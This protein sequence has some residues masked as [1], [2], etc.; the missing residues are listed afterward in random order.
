MFTPLLLP[1]CVR[2]EFMTTTEQVNITGFDP[3]FTTAVNVTSIPGYCVNNA[4]QCARCNSNYDYNTCTME[5]LVD[6]CVETSPIYN[7]TMCGSVGG[8][9]TTL[10]GGVPGSVLLEDLGIMEM[11]RE[12]AFTALWHQLSVYVLMLV[13]IGWLYF[14]DWSRRN[15][16][17]DSFHFWFP[18]A[19]DKKY[20]LE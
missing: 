3:Y 16:I 13:V 8:K 1:L 5:V 20:Q 14:R 2:R 17:T 11:P 15:I 4:A 12:E 10:S 6:T 19:R 18:A 9:N 7:S